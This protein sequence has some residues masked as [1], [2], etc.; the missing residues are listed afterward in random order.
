MKHSDPFSRQQL[1]SLCTAALL[2]PIL[3]LIPGS[4]APLAGRAAWA[5]PLAALPPLLAYGWLL[6]RIR[7]DMEPGEA[8]P[9]LC[10]RA[11]GKPLGKSVLLGLSA[12]LLLYGGFV[13]RAGAE[14]FLV[15]VYPRAEAALFVVSMG[16][17]G[18]LAALG[19]LQSLLRAARMALPILLTAL[20]LILLA[21]LGSLDKTELLPLTAADAGAL[22]RGA[23][24][25]LDLLA[26]GL[27]AYCF[28][29]PG[30]EEEP[31]RFGRTALW[32]M[33]MTLL[34]T[35]VG[36]AVQ[37][38]FGAALSARLAAPFFALVRNL[39]FFRSLERM[40]ALVVGLWLVPD[41]L[42]TGLVLHAAQRCLR[43]AVGT[44]P[45]PGEKRLAL[46][47][48]RWLIW[49]CGAIAI[50]LGLLLGPDPASLQL[51]SRAIIPLLNL[52]AA[53]LIPAVWFVGRAQKK[54]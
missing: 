44:P 34:L 36:A 24:P 7:G 40:E 4:A 15:T 18:L 54:L 12:W 32:T 2:S 27:V 37:G 23:F 21:G 9:E 39:V 52:F 50:G 5:G 31:G 8:L 30:G 20:L 42:L 16:L 46:S 43:L 14:R 25:A 22:L 51:W 49:L 6:G 28:F 1:R 48:G 35:A 41:F 26:F 47:N 13:L 45:G 10:L 3:R 53:A 19:P 38:R 17:L 11:L 29:R 33:E